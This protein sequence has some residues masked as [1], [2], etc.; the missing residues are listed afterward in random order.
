MVFVD[1][2]LLEELVD[3]LSILL[4]YSTIMT[5]EDMIASSDQIVAHV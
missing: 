1:D 3:L 2:G 5:Y 4:P